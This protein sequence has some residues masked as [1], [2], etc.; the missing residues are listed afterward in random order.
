MN[1]YTSGAREVP[2]AVLSRGWKPQIA[3][4]DLRRWRLQPWTD[5]SPAPAQRPLPCAAARRMPALRFLSLRS[6][7]RPS[8]SPARAPA[9]HQGQCLG[10]RTWWHTHPGL[11]PWTR[12]RHA[13]TSP[14]PPPSARSHDLAAAFRSPRQSAGERSARTERFVPVSLV[15]QRRT[16]SL[17]PRG[18]PHPGP[19]ARP[20]PPRALLAVPCLHRPRGPAAR[21]RHSAAARSL[22]RASRACG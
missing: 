14:A 8:H 1:S 4:S 10:P 16:A 15:L 9:P 7:L 20:S 5:R 17:A 21:L 3:K 18:R 13:H 12:R 22:P 2:P 11:R 19:S 6:P